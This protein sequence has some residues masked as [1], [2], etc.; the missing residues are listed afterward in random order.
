MLTV[1]SVQSDC[2]DRTIDMSWDCTWQRHMEG[3]ELLSDDLWSHI[4]NSFGLLVNI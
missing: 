4:P 2:V 1:Q 3:V